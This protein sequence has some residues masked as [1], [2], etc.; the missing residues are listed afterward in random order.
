MEGSS[1][2]FWFEVMDVDGDGLLTVEDIMTLSM[3]KRTGIIQLSIFL[4][5]KCIGWNF[6]TDVV[7]ILLPL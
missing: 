1:V 6:V 7:W 2:R 3:R 5:L 4:P